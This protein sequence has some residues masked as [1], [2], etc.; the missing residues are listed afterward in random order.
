MK[1]EGARLVGYR[2]I[3][4]A[5]IRDSIMIEQ[6]EEIIQKV[7]IKVDELVKSN[8]FDYQLIF[9][10]YGINGVM[11][12]LEPNKQPHPHELCLLIEAV[13]SNQK[14]SDVI[15]SLARSTL[16]HFGYPNRVATAGNLAFPFSPSDIKAGPVYEF[17]IYHLINIEDQKIFKM[18]EVQL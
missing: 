15:C 7:K 12:D 11:R 18:R 2:T 10:T 16:L 9:H 1:L 14:N 4:I 8:K 13:S 6:I 5:G 3:S 17:N